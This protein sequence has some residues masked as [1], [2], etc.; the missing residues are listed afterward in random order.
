MGNLGKRERGVTINLC[1]TVEVADGAT[2]DDSF[3]AIKAGFRRY[4]P[5]PGA[6]LEP[7]LSYSSQTNALR[8]SFKLSISGGAHD[9]GLADRGYAG[10]IMLVSGNA[11]RDSS[12]V[13]ARLES[14]D[15]LDEANYLPGPAYGS[16]LAAAYSAPYPWLSIPVPRNIANSDWATV[17]PTLANA[18][19][20]FI[21]DMSLNLTP[22]EMR[23][24]IDQ[25][26]T[27]VNRHITLFFNGTGRLSYL[28]ELANQ[29]VNGLQSRSQDVTVGIRICPISVGY[30][31]ME[32][33]RTMRIPLYAYTLGPLPTEPRGW[34]QSAYTSLVSLLGADILNV[35]LFSLANMTKG[36]LH[37]AVSAT[38]C[39]NYGETSIPAFTGGIEPQ[40]AYD[41]ATKLDPPYILHTMTPVFRAGVSKK[42]L[43]KRVRAICEGASAGRDGLSVTELFASRDR[44]VR[45]WRDLAI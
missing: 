32:H 25:L 16:N 23:R 15:V 2:P 36:T 24:R 28:S 37:E 27:R 1:Y 10:L 26:A 14:I 35:G 9:L 11:F 12:I 43:T 4:G 5:I 22:D 38:S 7:R 34:S 40:V 6:N 42:E 3:R 13:S 41:Y 17:A 30:S 44:R 29:I 21:T 19:V 39:A 45:N 8:T 33:L 20:T 31:V 18:G